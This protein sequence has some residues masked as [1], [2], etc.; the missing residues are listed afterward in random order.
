LICKELFGVPYVVYVYG[1]ETVRLGRGWVGRKLMKG[2]LDGSEWVVT[3]SEATSREFVAFGVCKGKIRRVYPGVDLT[4]FRPDPP[5]QVLLERY[6]LG[7]RRVLLTVARLDQRKGHDTVMRAIARER[8]RLGEAVYLIVGTGREEG[9]LRNLAKE[10]GLE[11]R[12]IFVGYV[13]DGELPGY[14]TLCDLFVMPN[15][16]TEGTSLAGD[17]EG[18]GITFIEAAACGKPSIGGRSGGAVEA[19]VDGETGFLVDPLS[20]EEVAS[21]IVRLLE[22]HELRER[23]GRKGRERVERMFDWRIVARQVEEIL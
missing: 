16:V 21:A 6:R 18:F 17:V 8:E 22:D 2:I 12:V 4:V 13:P 3:N 14:Y 19:I 10:L 20:V 1:S 15:R 9:R 11:D 23:L 5:D 7:G